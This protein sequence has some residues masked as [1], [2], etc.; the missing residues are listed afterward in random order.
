MKWSPGGESQDI[1]DR[2]DQRG[3]AGFQFAACSKRET[4][5][6]RWGLRLPSVMTAYKKCPLDMSVRNRSL[7]VLPS[8]G[9][10]GSTSV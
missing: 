9:C 3:G 10:T 2:R 7:M 8:S 1:E 5:N 4:Y 6:R